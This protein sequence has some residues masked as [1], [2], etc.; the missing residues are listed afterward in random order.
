MIFFVIYASTGFATAIF[1]SQAKNKVFY[2][3]TMHNIK[4]DA[5]LDCIAYYRLK[6]YIYCV[7]IL[8]IVYECLYL[9]PN[10]E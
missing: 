4:K 8:K 1:P 9:T 7:C 10:L 2:I 5:I 6:C 3:S